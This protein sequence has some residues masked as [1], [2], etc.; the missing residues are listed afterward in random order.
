MLNNDS[1]NE[2]TIVHASIPY[3]EYVEENISLIDDNIK[4][5]PSKKNKIIAGFEFNFLDDQY[6]FEKIFSNVYKAPEYEEGYS[7]DNYKSP[8]LSRNYTAKV[9]K[10]L[11]DKLEKS[12]DEINS[13]KL[14][15]ILFENIEVLYRII[16]SMD[17]IPSQTKI[18]HF[19]QL[20]YKYIYKKIYINVK[21]CRNI[22][23]EDNVKN[24]LLSIISVDYSKG[25]KNVNTHFEM[26]LHTL[27]FFRYLLCASRLSKFN[28][29]QIADLISRIITKIVDMYLYLVKN[30]KNSKDNLN[31]K[32]I[33]YILT[34]KD[35]PG[36]SFLDTRL[37]TLVILYVDSYS[38]IETF[39]EHL[40]KD[41]PHI[42]F[43]INFIKYNI[44]LKK[45]K[46]KH[47][48]F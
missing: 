11:F 37:A 27:Y 24:N 16:L 2:S 43:N 45:I 32:L 14:D 48:I 22:A 20:L 3:D 42:I 35:Y 4:F 1:L 9:I 15:E 17:D 36:V 33:D 23:I 34:F 25:V 29:I 19:K 13:I 12:S 7:H 40:P 28:Y 31:K 30:K 8:F 10:T 41:Q 5:Y 46:K 47:V 21:S 39:L 26:A 38:E 44:L 18:W 6:N